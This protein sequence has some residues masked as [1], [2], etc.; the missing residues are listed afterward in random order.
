[1]IITPQDKFHWKIL[2]CGVKKTT[3]TYSYD[4]AGNRLSTATVTKKSNVSGNETVSLTHENLYN[5]DGS[6]SSILNKDAKGELFYEYDDF[7]ETSIHGSSALKNEISYTGGIYDES[8]GVY[9]LN[10][11]YYD[12][13]NGRFLTKIPIGEK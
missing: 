7:G 6:T 10:A 13:G 12:P 5:G 1:M 9:Y 8:T 3:T 4:S 11:R 2:S